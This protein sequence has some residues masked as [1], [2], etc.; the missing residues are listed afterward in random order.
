MVV[1]LSHSV[2][3]L[4]AEIRSECGEMRLVLMHENRGNRASAAPG[5][6]LFGWNG[7]DQW[8]VKGVSHVWVNLAQ[9]QEQSPIGVDFGCVLQPLFFERKVCLS[10]RDLDVEPVPDDFRAIVW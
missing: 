9:F 4:P 8:N 3:F 5:G 10:R 7:G 1:F 2:V 6:N